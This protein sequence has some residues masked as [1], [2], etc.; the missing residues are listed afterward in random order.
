MI[1]LQYSLTI[2]ATEEPDFFTFY[3][4]DLEGFS[5]TGHSIEDCIYKARWGMLEHI[6]LLKNQGLSVPLKN[7]DPQIIVQNDR[8]LVAA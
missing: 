6:D 7:P 4:P 1:D 5:G 3:S 8:S 2:E